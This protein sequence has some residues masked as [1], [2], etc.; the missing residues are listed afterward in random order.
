[1]SGALAARFWGELFQMTDKEILAVTNLVHRMS[2]ILF[3]NRDFRRD[4]GDKRS[5]GGI[6]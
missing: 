3:F 6:S 2:P 5:N 4:R 1:M